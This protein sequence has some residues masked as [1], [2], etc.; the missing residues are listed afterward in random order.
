MISAG[1]WHAKCRS[2]TRRRLGQIPQTADGEHL[3]LFHSRFVLDDRL[4][5]EAGLSCRF[6]P[7]IEDI[8][9]AGGI[10]KPVPPEDAVEPAIPNPENL[11]DAGHRA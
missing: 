9:S 3:I 4:S 6:I 2:V 11:G 7:D 1:A 5:I 10:D 8:L